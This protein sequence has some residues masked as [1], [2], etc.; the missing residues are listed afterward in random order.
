MNML[1]IVFGSVFYNDHAFYLT[2]LRILYLFR[3]ITKFKIFEFIK[4]IIRI[5]K[6]AIT[7][8]VAIF[9]LNVTPSSLIK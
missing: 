7:Q 2:V 9:A 6:M 4:K 8:L 1:I 5:Y 3:Y